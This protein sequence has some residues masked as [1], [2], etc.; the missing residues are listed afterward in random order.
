MVQT[1]GRTGARRRRESDLLRLADRVANFSLLLDGGGRVLQ[2]R[3]APACSGPDAG[4]LAGRPWQE[5][6][7]AAARAPLTRLLAAPDAAGWV[8][9]AWPRPEGGVCHLEATAVRLDGGGAARYLCLFRDATPREAALAVNRLSLVERLAA[10]F[11]HDL[12]NVTATLLL[13][14]DLLACA[15][16]GEAERLVERLVS[17][18]QKGALIGRQFAALAG[19]AGS[20]A[21]AVAVA[22]LL[23][24][25]ADL[26][27]PVA[28]PDGIRLH[29]TAEPG[30][31]VAADPD[32]L[33][34]ALLNLLFQARAGAG[35]QGE[36]HV[37][38]SGEDEQ[39]R[40]AVGHAGAPAPAGADLAAARDLALAL[41]GE[42][43]QEGAPGRDTIYTL[44]LPASPASPPEQEGSPCASSSPT[45][46]P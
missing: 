20:S 31:A 15:G 17:G 16:P 26:F 11:A 44:I 9:L 3:G 19:G 40:I 2:A 38:A 41:G 24:G 28:R 46:N 30:L 33:Q 14:A 22:P 32:R 12:N 1:T 23:A 45:T 39:V 27:A 7:P 35:G 25:L 13:N 36:I 6:I 4:A 21:G 34:Q 10:R 29:W 43:A 8:P 5:V 18:A 42:L 37:A